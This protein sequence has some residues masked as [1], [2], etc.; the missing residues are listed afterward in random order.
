MAELPK[1]T[2]T[3]RFLL[4]SKT[5]PNKIDRG[6]L[7]ASSIGAECWRA[8]W[9]S[10]HFVNFRESVSIRM[11]RI[12]DIG[13]KEEQIV[14]SELIDAGIS[15]FKKDQENNTIPM[16]GKKEEEQEEIVGFAGHVIGHPDGRVIGLIESKAEHLL[17][18]K[19]ANKERF[20]QFV[21]HGVEEASPEYFGQMQWLM[22]KMKL[23]RALFVMTNKNNS[24]R[25][26][27]R[28]RFNKREAEA[29]ERKSV[30]IVTSTEPPERFSDSRNWLICNYC[31]HRSQCW[32]FTEPE[33]NCRT[34]E[35]S[36]IC[37][38]GKWECSLHETNLTLQQQIEG[39]G[40]WEKG[41]NL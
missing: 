17:E 5:I 6:Y 35:H 2:N 20:T 28:V 23:N 9:Y 14:I 40:N 39:C 10:F 11:Q 36:D 25:H 41:W 13:H 19:T 31:K 33:K 26:Y 29:L 27:E 7:G 22:L 24:E 16:T 32:D 4:E 12:F 30:V 37:D 18:I 1:D 21:R 3:T 15:V 8:L 34:C 38:D